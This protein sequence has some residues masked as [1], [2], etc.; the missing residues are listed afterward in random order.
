MSDTFTLADLT[1][2]EQPFRAVAAPAIETPPV[3]PD[4]AESPPAEEPSGD[5]VVAADSTPADAADEPAPE[6][7]RGT[8]RERIEE[9]VA[10]RNAL[11]KFIDYREAAWT[12]SPPAAATA[13]PPA[14]ETSAPS[15]ESCQYDTDKW[16]KA[17]NAWTQTQIQTGVKQ[18]LQSERQTAT[19]ET[20]KAKFEERMDAFA[21]ATPDI[22][23]VLGNPSLPQLHKDA[24]ALVVGSELGPQILYHLGK[25]P[26]KAARIA[27]QS[28]I[29]QAAAVGRLEVELKTAKVPQRQLSNAPA[30]PTTTRG[31]GAAPISTTDPKMDLAEFMKRERQALAERRRRH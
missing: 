15:L 18:A 10:E 21:K 23:V 19:V 13:A 9:L 6:A 28:P 20:N 2:S 1:A 26:E 22:K 30:P 16:T 12:Q 5:V 25:N 29:E 4:P 14:A 11:K 7:P 24:A 27:R 8:A 17:M 3:E 31:A